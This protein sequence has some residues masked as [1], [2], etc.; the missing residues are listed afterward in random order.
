MKITVKMS[1]KQVAQSKL[2]GWSAK[3]MRALANEMRNAITTRTFSE[4][5]GID[6]KPLP[7]HASLGLK[8]PRHKDG[9]YSE[10][11]GLI[12]EGKRRAPGRKRPSRK[13]RNTKKVD[14]VFSGKMLRQFKIRRVT[15]FSAVLGPTGASKK[16]AGFT[17]DLRPWMGM[18]PSNR[19][20]VA[21]A[22]RAILKGVK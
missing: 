5:R 12:R 11:W 21:K 4:G 7:T 14:L 9:A 13:S 18:S 22:F 19:K 15:R 17:N 1:R 3:H 2:T 10:G 8:G 20:T 6:D 16:Y